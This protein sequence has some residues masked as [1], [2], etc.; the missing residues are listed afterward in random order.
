MISKTEAATF[1]ALPYC[2]V[3]SLLIKPRTSPNATVPKTCA[4]AEIK[5]ML[6]IS[7]V[8]H[9][10]ALATA[11]NGSQWFGINAWINAK[12]KVP[13]TRLNIVIVFSSQFAS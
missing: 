13:A 12:M 6:V 1:I 2:S 7:L 3:S 11:T 8:F 5:V 9:A 10:S 4:V